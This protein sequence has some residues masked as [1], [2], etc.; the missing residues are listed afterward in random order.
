MFHL[1]RSYK[2]FS[3]SKNIKQFVPRTYLN[4]L[5][6]ISHGNCM[7]LSFHVTFMKVNCRM[8]QVNFGDH[9]NIVDCLPLCNKRFMCKLQL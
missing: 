7:H 3:G 6:F 4:V 9:C 1:L 2:H 5:A 8:L